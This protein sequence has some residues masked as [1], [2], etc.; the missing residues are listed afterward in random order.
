M[1]QL[2]NAHLYTY[3]EQKER[4]QQFTALVLFITI[5]VSYW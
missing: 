4:L 1:S 5:V 2:K 3:Q